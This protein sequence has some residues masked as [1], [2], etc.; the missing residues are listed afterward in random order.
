MALKK[1]GNHLAEERPSG[2]GVRLTD[3]YRQLIESEQQ[4]LVV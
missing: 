4:T 2:E 3:K 1:E